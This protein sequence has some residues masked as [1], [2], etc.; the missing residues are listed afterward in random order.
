M[1]LPI[2]AHFDL[3]VALIIL[4][5]LGTLI[6][7]L[8][9]V[10]HSRTNNLVEAVN[11]FDK[12]LKAKD[13]EMTDMQERIKEL[14]EQLKELPALRAQIVEWQT[15]YACLE[16]ELTHWKTRYEQLECEF[17]AMRERE[18]G[19]LSRRGGGAK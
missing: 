15:K 2:D 19:P 16:D 14:Q 10:E 1:N 8:W 6:T 4:A 12:L 18:K 5:A 13:S 9:A 11:A 3:G 7:V 17:K